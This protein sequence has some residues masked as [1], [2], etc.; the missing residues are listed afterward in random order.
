MSEYQRQC[1][2]QG[3]RGSRNQRSEPGSEPGNQNQA[4]DANNQKSRGQVGQ[5][6]QRM[7]WAGESSAE[8]TDKTVQQCNCVKG[9]AYIGSK[10]G[11]TDQ[12]NHAKE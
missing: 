12:V 3:Q 5:I 11:A 4:Y 7:N 6:R 9:A 8:R 1:Q 10:T 2:S